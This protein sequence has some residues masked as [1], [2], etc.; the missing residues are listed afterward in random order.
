MSTCEGDYIEWIYNVFGECVVTTREKLSFAFGITS[1]LIW[2]WAQ[3]PQI[4]MNFRTKRVDGLSI[5]FLLL[6]VTGDIS[7]LVGCILTHGLVTQKITSIFFCCVDITCTLQHC[8]YTYIYRRFCQNEHD[9]SLASEDKLLAYTPIAPG[10]V[11]TAAA[12]LTREYPNPYSKE[13]ITGSLIGWIS[14]LVYSSSRVFQIIKNFIRKRTDG[15]SI[16]FFISAW[17]GN[18]TYAVSIFLKDS[19]WG[20]IWMQFPWL[21]GSMGPLILD[22]IVLLQFFLYRKNSDP[23]YYAI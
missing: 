6:L 11:A 21:V 22:F 8:Y 2:M 3:L 13:Y 18:S 15:L 19:N 12:V 20:Y 16:Q 1:T 23:S 9:E 4:Y 7:N 10:L 17:L 5:G 14:G